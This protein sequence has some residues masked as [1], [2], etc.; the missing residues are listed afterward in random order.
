MFLKGGKDYNETNGIAKG[1]SI[2]EVSRI[3]DLSQKTIREY[4]QLGM[5]KPNRHPRT[6][7]RIYSEFEVEQI[8]RIT[9]LI[10][11]EGLTLACIRRITQLAPCWKIFDCEVK[12]QCPAFAHANQPCYEVRLSKNTKCSGEC[13]HCVV[14][15]NRP[16]AQ[17][18]KKK[19]F[20][21]AVPRR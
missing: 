1:F 6:N 17:K 13:D 7:N 5:F 16:D 12:E 20:P 8:R 21:A 14:F 15:I 2:G 10:H 3:V 4:E 19:K 11:N 9:R 18:P